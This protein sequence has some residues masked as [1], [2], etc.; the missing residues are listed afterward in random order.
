MEPEIGPIRKR[1]EAKI[2]LRSILGEFLSDCS[3][4]EPCWYRI[5]GARDEYI[6]NTNE[7]SHTPA[8]SKIFGM[9]DKLS[10]ELL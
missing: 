1:S 6:P 9:N 8:L 4:L 10:D 5:F 3:V 2:A 7:P